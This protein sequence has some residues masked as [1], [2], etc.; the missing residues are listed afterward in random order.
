MICKKCKPIKIEVV[1]RG[2]IT[3]TTSILLYGHI[4]IKD[5]GYTAV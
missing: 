4:I 5:L 1:V 3:G 2:Y